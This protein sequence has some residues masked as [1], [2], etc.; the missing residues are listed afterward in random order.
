[1][2]HRHALVLGYPLVVGRFADAVFFAR[3]ANLGTEFDLSQYADYPAFAEFRFLYVETPLGDFLY[4][5]MAQDF[6][7][8]SMQCKNVLLYFFKKPPSIMQD[9][10]MRCRHFNHERSFK[11]QN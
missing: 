8:V 5:T 11:C 6:K 4:F 2:R 3:L 7:E 10:S 9:T 1:M